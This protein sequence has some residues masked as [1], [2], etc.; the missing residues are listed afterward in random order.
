MIPSEVV[1]P[2]EKVL[3]KALAAYNADD[4]TAFNANFAKAAHPPADEHTFRALFDGIYRPEFGSYT[5]KA[6]LPAESVPDPN[7]GQ[8]TY[9]AT[10][11]KRARVKMS[12]DFVRED[13]GLKI[14][15]LRLEKM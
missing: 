12:A 1:A 6:L 5:S 3:D 10:F 8:L 13:G 2:F 11:A 4:A 9:N 7:Y 15:Q 14:V